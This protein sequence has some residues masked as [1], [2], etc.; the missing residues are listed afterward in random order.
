ME[1][2]ILVRTLK[3]LIKAGCIA[4]GAPKNSRSRRLHLTE[5]GRNTL[6]QGTLL[7]KAAQE[8]IRHKLGKDHQQIMEMPAAFDQL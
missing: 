2:S 8:N 3:P 1:K 4:D 6:A 7:W 5:N